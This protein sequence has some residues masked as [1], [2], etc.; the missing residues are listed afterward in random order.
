MEGRSP[1]DYSKVSDDSLHEDVDF[2]INN[3]LDGVEYTQGTRPKYII[4]S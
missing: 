4:V 1:Y 2:V 3:F